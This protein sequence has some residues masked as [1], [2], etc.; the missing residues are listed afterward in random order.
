MNHFIRRIL[1]VVSGLSALWFFYWFFIYEMVVLGKQFGTS[2]LR[3]T[4]VINLL[5]LATSLLAFAVFSW[6]RL[7]GK[8]KVSFVR[9]K[10]TAYML[11]QA[12]YWYWAIVFTTIFAAILVLIPGLENIDLVVYTRY[13]LGS[14]YVLCFPGYTVIRA[15]LPKG[16]L[17][18]IETIALS[19]GMSLASVSLI[20][21]LLAYSPWGI[22]TVSVT[23]S[24]FAI[25]IACGTG[26][27][28]R[29]YLSLAQ[30]GRI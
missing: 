6:Q 8:I 18:S 3:A 29:E 11:S 15:I 1:Q 28:I 27:F 14:I 13:L 25:T 30:K 19:L 23:L 12:A 26:A 2:A 21:L 5:G 22:R 4:D 9:Q 24:I 7:L 16:K 10:F 20:G 17:K